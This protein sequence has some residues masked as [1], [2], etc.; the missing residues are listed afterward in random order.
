MQWRY[1]RPQRV[2][3]ESLGGKKLLFFL[4]IYENRNKQ[5]HKPCR[6]FHQYSQQGKIRAED[7]S[8]GEE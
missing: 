4:Y 1:E 8:L 7:R 5:V 3:K 2:Y 6:T